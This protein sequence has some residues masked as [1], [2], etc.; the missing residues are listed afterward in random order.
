MQGFSY[1]PRAL[2]HTAERFTC[3]RWS[4]VVGNAGKEPTD[5]RQART[6]PINRSDVSGCHTP[7]ENP[8]TTGLEKE[9]IWK[10]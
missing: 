7:R 9:T 6:G 4:L 8:N 2:H 5:L 3:D 10:F 1:R